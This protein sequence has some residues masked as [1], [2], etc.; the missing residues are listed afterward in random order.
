MHEN[1]GEFEGDGAR[2][3]AKLRGEFSI[4][5]IESVGIT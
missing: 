3:I 1:T 5:N 2:P 4:A